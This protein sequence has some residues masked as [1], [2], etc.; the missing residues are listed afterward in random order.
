MTDAE[1]SA[2]NISPDLLSDAK[3]VIY[4][5]PPDWPGGQ[6]TVLAFR[7]TADA[8]DVVVDHDQALGLE[9]SQ[10]KAAVT[11]GQSVEKNLGSNG[12]GHRPFS[13]RR[14][15]DGGW[16]LRGATGEWFFL[17]RL[18]S[19]PTPSEGTGTGS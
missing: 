9:T 6:Q 18:A 1:L 4:Q 12:S 7:G 16:N 8:A 13:W 2:K 11:L 10:Y 14:Q 15:G 19:T 17:I 5:T 3:A